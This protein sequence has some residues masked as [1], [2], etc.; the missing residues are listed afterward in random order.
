V[1][2]FS[3][4]LDSTTLLY[5]LR[6]AGHFVKGLS[7]NYGQRHLAKEL[8]AART[9]TAALGVEH[10]T[11]DLRSLVAFLGR[12]SLTDHRVAVP[13]GEYSAE[14]MAAT[15]VPNRNMV[16]LSVALAWAVST[17][18]E[19]VAFGAHGGEY[20]PYPDCQ[21]PFA[22]AMDL[23]AQRCHTTP[24]R[25]LTPFVEWDKAAIVRRGAALGVPFGLTW[26]CYNG[27]D[28]HCGSCGTCVDRRR[29]FERAGVPDPTE[30]AGG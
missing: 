29:A 5:H 3:G 17:N 1:V 9:I 16:L 28:L 20:T 12:N 27:R 26:S 22:A 18:F 10:E 14:T 19:A 6:D 11:V 23:A 4:G 30:Y 25:V 13:E 2:V 24:V 8:A 21:P 7:V 15:V